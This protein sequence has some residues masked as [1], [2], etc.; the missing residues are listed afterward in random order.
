MHADLLCSLLFDLDRFL[1]VGS[2]LLV[3]AADLIVFR[4]DLSPE[5]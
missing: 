5:S 1:L 2:A 4:E 3:V